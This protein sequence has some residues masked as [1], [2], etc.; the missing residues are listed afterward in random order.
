MEDFKI[1]IISDNPEENQDKIKFE[2]LAYKNTFVDIITSSENETPLVIGLEGRWG[3]GKTT[4]MK[5]IRAELKKDYEKEIKDGRRRC[6]SVW[7]ESWKYN[8]ADNL[9]A[10]LLETIVQEM[11]RGNF[12]EKATKE[13]I[14]LGKKLNLKAIPQMIANYLSLPSKGFEIIKEE[15]YKKRLPY[16]SLFSPFFHE[17]VRHW[18]SCD[19]TFKIQKGEASQLAEI[20][21]KKAVLVVFIDDLDR[22]S[23][24]NIIKVLEAIKLFLNFKGCVFVLGVSREVIVS[25]FKNVE[26]IKEYGNE[27]LEKIFQVSYELPIIHK[28]DMKKYFEEKAREF[29]Y[30]DTLIR[31]S[32]VVIKS[33]GETPRKIK[34]FFNNLSIQIKI[35]HEKGLFKKD[36]IFEQDHIE[37]IKVDDYIYWNVIKEAFKNIHS[38]IVRDS[39]IVGRVKEEYKKHRD[40]LESGK[41]KDFESIN[42]EGA[43][44]ILQ[45][46]TVRD[47][48]LS[49]P[50]N[51]EIIDTLIY[52]S[53]SIGLLPATDEDERVMKIEVP[54]IGSMV[55][56]EKGNF[57]YSDEKKE[58]E[59][60]FEIDVYPVTNEEYCK[61]LN[62][63]KPND[64][65]L[66]KWIYL[67]GSYGNERCRIRKEESKYNIERGYEKHP[68][69]YVSWYGADTY[70]KWA[71]K[72]L[73]TEEEWEK[74]ARGPDGRVY[75]WG[76]KFDASL[77]NSAESGIRGTTEVDRYP[78]GKSYYGCYDMAGNVWEWTDSWYDNKKEFKILRGGSWVDEEDKCRCASRSRYPLDKCD[79]GVGFRCARTIKL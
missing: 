61:F 73:P 30:R 67:N 6:K 47:I 13:V 29:S 79:V 72:R 3:R 27:Y 51:H 44:I 38:Y 12:F 52:E 54:S 53:L 43:R 40:G 16:L 55:K 46:K 76:G 59:N 2:F 48:V 14:K 74:A 34:K 75:P 45:D 37:K 69:I 32:D 39:K 25:A 23:Y 68:V 62:D 66:E 1:K 4:L 60:D 58:I 63:K 22:C 78:N 18:L 64:E 5:A 17:L 7:F 33:L 28:E 57:L 8:D 19:D 42:P 10:A 41:F 35:A 9:L 36:F 26:H 11:G 24:E 15:D 77:C 71:D 70:A 56:V 20:D 65:E 49:L 50:K 21:D 31:Y